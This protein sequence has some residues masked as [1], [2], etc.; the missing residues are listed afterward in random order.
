MKKP[1]LKQLLL[2]LLGIGLFIIALIALGGMLKDVSIPQLVDEL[3]AIP[4]H[5]L[6][7]AIGLTIATYLVMTGYDM[8]GIS[9]AGKHL[10]LRKIVI[11]AFVGDAF[12]NSLGLST[13]LGNSIRYRFYSAWGLSAKDIAKTIG[14][15]TVS[16]WVGFCLLAGPILLFGHSAIDGIL[17]LPQIIFRS[18]GG[19]LTIIG[20]AYVLFVLIR[21]QPVGVGKWRLPV[22]ST[23]VAA[24]LTVV[25]M[26]DWIMSASVFY[27]VLP[28]GAGVPFTG[29]VAVYIVAHLVGNVSQLP[30]GIAVFE[31]VAMAYLSTIVPVPAACASLLVFRAVFY[32]APFIISL[33]LMAMFEVFHVGRALNP[34]AVG[35]LQNDRP[36][37]DPKLDHYDR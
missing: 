25:G 13:I 37:A 2:P 16:Y 33:I 23:K 26:L 3:R 30:A 19:V 18:L 29:F 35:E 15:F 31:A 27:L 10:P 5:R 32:L 17:H 12:N 14:I 4:K 24:G 7:S 9:Y 34:F 20:T 21:H 36:G 28:A 1:T 22:P 8:L 11:A 6:L